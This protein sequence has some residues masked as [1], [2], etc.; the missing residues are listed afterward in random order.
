M[1]RCSGLALAVVLFARNRDVV[2]RGRMVG[3]QGSGGGDPGF[4]LISRTSLVDTGL[5]ADGC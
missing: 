5:C 4:L 3:K 1:S 2:R